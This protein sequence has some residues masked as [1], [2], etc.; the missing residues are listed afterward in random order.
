MHTTPLTY[1]TKTLLQ[2]LHTPELLVVMLIRLRV[3]ATYDPHGQY[4]SWQQG[5][6]AAGVGSDG[7]NAF[8]MLMQLVTLALRWPLDVRSLRCGG[9]GEAE[10]W[11]LRAISLV[12]HDRV[13]TAEATLAHWLPPGVSRIATHHMTRFASALSK[14]QLVLPLRSY[15]TGPKAAAAMRG[16]LAAVH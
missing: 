3:A 9:L 11:L 7:S 10:A 2:E 14:T 16:G 15:R 6:Q 12:Q 1:S 4:E 5:L 13:E 8:D